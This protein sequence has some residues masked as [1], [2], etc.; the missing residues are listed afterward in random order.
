MYNNKIRIFEKLKNCHQCAIC[1][2]ENALNIILECGHETCVEYY[3]KFKSSCYFNF[4]KN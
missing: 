2:E 3:D 4:C 1:L